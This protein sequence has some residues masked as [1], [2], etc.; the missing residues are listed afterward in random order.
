MAKNVRFKI[1]INFVI[2]TLLNAS[3]SVIKM[4]ADITPNLYMMGNSA[5]WKRLIAPNVRPDSL[6]AA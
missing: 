5:D 6:A 3:S 1:K 2:N 4:T